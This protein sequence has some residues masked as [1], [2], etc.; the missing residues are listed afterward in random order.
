MGDHL[1]LLVDRLLTES[2]LEAAIGDRTQSNQLTPSPNDDKMID[3]SSHMDFESNMSPRQLV[4]CRICQDEDEDS[5]METPCSCC[6]SLKY[7]HRRCVQ[8]WCNEKGNTLCEICHQQFKPGYTASP[9][10]F[11]F[12]GVSTNLRGN[13]EVGRRD[14]NNPRFLTMVSTDHNFLHPN[15]DEYA[16]STSRSLTCYCSVAIIFMVLLVLRHTLPTLLSGANNNAFPLFVLLIVRYLG[17]ILP[18]YI[19]LR[20]VSARQRLRRQQAAN[21]TF[22]LSD[23]EA[24]MARHQSHIIHAL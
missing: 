17:I 20:A 14:L 19:I 2:T 6:G 21:E 9:P 15:Y 8:R 13:W 22:S 7:A 3:C 24:D 11:H 12:R 4:E 5:R 23:E 10:L 18:M 16:N 1:V